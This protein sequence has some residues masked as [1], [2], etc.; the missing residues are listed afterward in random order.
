[1]NRVGDSLHHNGAN[2]E[3]VEAFVSREVQFL[4]VGGLAVA[5]YVAT[6]AADDMDLLLNPTEQNSARVSQALAGLG[7]HGFQANS[8]ARLGLQV[9]LKQHLYAELLTP[10]EGGVAY[11]EMERVSV[12]AKLFGIPVRL[13]SPA[14]LISMKQAAVAAAAAQSEKHRKDIKLLEPHVV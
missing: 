3:L 13:A 6:R 14:S 11:A 10:Q 2:K 4:V 12:P 7:L 8:F 5:W 1:M 9:P